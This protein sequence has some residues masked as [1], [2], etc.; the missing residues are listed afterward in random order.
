VSVLKG[1]SWGGSAYEL[2]GYSEEEGGGSPE[3]LQE[4]DGPIT[5]AQRRIAKLQRRRCSKRID[6][7]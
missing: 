1:L 7:G 5:L 4:E 2:L 3:W 6:A